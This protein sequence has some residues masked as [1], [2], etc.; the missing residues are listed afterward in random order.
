MHLSETC[1]DDQPHLITHVATTVATEADIEA[2]GPIH[3][4]LAER[5]SLP[6]EH[7]VDA[8]YGS[9]EVLVTSQADYGIDVICP[10]PPDLSWQAQD[11]QA[12]G[13]SD[14]SI[15]WEN[16]TVVCPD[17]RRSHHWIPGRGPRGKPTIQVQ[18]RH[19]DCRAC[20]V[21]APCTRS[22]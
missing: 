13:V 7:L 5:D 19:A 16:Q 3:R 1:D 18:F 12:F 17:G 11:A 6:R 14:F 22:T 21:R 15:D 2:L 8:A 20:A 4:D 10:V 9:A